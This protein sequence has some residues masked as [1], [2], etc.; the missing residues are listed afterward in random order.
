MN[1]FFAINTHSQWGLLSL[2]FGTGF[3][4]NKKYIVEIIKIMVNEIRNKIEQ[5]KNT[6]LRI[7][8]Q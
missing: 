2:K 5:L 3:Y 1:D 7:P 6:L 4:G 8:T